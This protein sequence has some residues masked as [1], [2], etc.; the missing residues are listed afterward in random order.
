MALLFM[1]VSLCAHAQSPPSPL[2]PP[3]AG[4]YTTSWVGNTF[5]GNGSGNGYG[6]WVQEGV[7]KMI[8]TPDG[9]A[10]CGVG[11]DEAGR[12]IG[13]YKNGSP[14]EVLLQQE[15]HT[16]WG[17][18]TANQASAVWGNIIFIANTA[19]QLLRFQWVPGDINSAEYLG[20]SPLR[21]QV[22]AIGLA[23]SASHVV[24]SYKDGMVEVRNSDGTVVENQF[25]LQG[26]QA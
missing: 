25:A 21:Q 2:Y 11:W 23:A 19:N 26:V 6:Y 3:P 7:A 24:V 22:D 8:V 13:L 16:A 9:T 12:C 18:G 14:N 17:F 5:G 10:M 4:S 20:Y 15:N 1:K